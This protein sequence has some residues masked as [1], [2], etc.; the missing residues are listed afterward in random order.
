[1][2]VA[3]SSRRR[4]SR[5]ARASQGVHPRL[6]AHARRKAAEAALLKTPEE[7]PPHVR[8]SCSRPPIRK[9]SATPSAVARSTSNF[10]YFRWTFSSSTSAGWPPTPVLISTD[11]AV[12]SVLR[13]GGGSARDPSRRSSWSPP[14]VVRH[15]RR[16]RSTSVEGVHRTRSR[17]GHLPSSPTPCCKVVDPARSPKRSSATCATASLALMAPGLVQLPC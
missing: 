2:E 4:F 11:A 8:V 5:H 15:Q 12:E 7:L 3:T 6:S 10:I 14:A 17:A 16:R 9:R 13:Q 1:M